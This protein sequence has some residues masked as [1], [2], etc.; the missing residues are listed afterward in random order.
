M[1]EYDQREIFILCTTQMLDAAFYTLTVYEQLLEVLISLPDGPIKETYI[2]AMRTSIKTQK[3]AIDE[4]K[5]M[6][7]R[8]EALAD[9]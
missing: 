9:G 5:R 1:S 7:V 8:A 4:F 3:N 6:L 2:K